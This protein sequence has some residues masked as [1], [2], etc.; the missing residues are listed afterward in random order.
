ML[1]ALRMLLCS[2]VIFL[3][4]QICRIAFE[5]I[6]QGNTACQS[7]PCWSCQ[8]IKRKLFRDRKKES[9]K[10][11]LIKKCRRISFRDSLA[12]VESS[13][14]LAKRRGV[15]SRCSWRMWSEMLSPTP[16]T[17]IERQ[18]P[19]WMS[20]MLWRDRKIYMEKALTKIPMIKQLKNKVDT[21]LKDNPVVKP[22]KFSLEIYIYI[23]RWRHDHP[24]QDFSFQWVVYSVCW[25]RATTRSKSVFEPQFTGIPCQDVRLFSSTWALR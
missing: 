6:N 21:F 19:L 3:L 1:G 18:S 5:R 17:L 8:R 14:F 20:S 15:Y 12:V 24:E 16:S 13:V 11:S 4:T 22:D 7:V 9:S 2:S 10:G 25:G 23:I